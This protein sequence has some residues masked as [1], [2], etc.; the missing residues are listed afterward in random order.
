[1]CPPWKFCDLL[2]WF[3]RVSFKY[4][5]K[6]L[7]EVCMLQMFSTMGVVMKPS[8]LHH[9]VGAGK[10][11]LRYSEFWSSTKCYWEQIQTTQKLSQMSFCL[12]HIRQTGI[13]KVTYYD[14]EM[15]P[16]WGKFP[17]GFCCE[18]VS[19]IPNHI[20]YANCPKENYSILHFSPL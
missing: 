11:E 14:A 8:R 3:G 17:S 10:V 6:K 12:K 20:T 7:L 15:N 16:W 18:M 5:L 19:H 9:F 4:W 13:Y 1:M 2:S